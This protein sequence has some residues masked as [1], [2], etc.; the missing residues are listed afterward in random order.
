MYNARH[1]RQRIRTARSSTTRKP[2]GLS[3]FDFYLTGH[4]ANP[5][6]ASLTRHSNP[7]R[8]PEIASLTHCALLTRSHQ[9][10]RFP[11]AR[12]ITRTMDQCNNAFI[13]QNYRRRP[14]A[15][16][17]LASIRR[18]TRDT[19]VLSCILRRSK[20][21]NPWFGTMWMKSFHAREVP[22]RGQ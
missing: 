10:D 12:V 20:G 18:T 7:A 19:I 14:R 11:A 13:K 1:S 15:L 6:T 17:D 16:S 21:K 2:F 9:R 22:C 4:E 5:A 3:L 8:K